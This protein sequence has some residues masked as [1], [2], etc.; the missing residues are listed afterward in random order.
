MSYDCI[1]YIHR[2]FLILVIVDYQ[3][4]NIAQTVKQNL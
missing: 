3:N 4:V 2:L 1:S